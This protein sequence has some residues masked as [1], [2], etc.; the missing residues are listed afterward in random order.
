MIC[1][2][3]SCLLHLGLFTAG[4]PESNTPAASP[5]SRGISIELLTQADA[6]VQQAAVRST[7]ATTPVRNVP[8][9]RHRSGTAVAPPPQAGSKSPPGNNETVAGSMTPVKQGA[10]SRERDIAVNDLLE[11][12]I[13][14]ALQP[15]FKY[16]VL[17]RRRGWEGIVRIGLRV[18]PDGMIT[19]LHI[20]EPSS[21]PVLDR[22]AMASLHDTG[23]LPAAGEWLAGSHFD[24]VLPVEYRLL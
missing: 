13:R 14:D 11:K 23:Q 9:T 15:H 8:Q 4:W 19:R 1:L 5:Q 3:V 7:P 22:A 21:H 6:S 10:A 2:T 17:A 20:V 12:A 24:I 18:E 16:P